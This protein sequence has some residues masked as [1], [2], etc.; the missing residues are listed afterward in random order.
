MSSY[1][2]CMARGLLSVSLICNRYEVL[3][4]QLTYVV[5]TVMFVDMY[6]RLYSRLSATD[7]VKKTQ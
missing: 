5:A 1:S 6:G 2:S 4:T 3:E 7:D